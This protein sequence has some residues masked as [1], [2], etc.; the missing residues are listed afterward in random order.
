[1][2]PTGSGDSHTHIRAAIG[3]LEFDFWFDKGFAP[4][5]Q[6]HAIESHNHSL[7]ELHFIL[8]GS[9]TLYV[10]Q[11]EQPLMP[12]TW[13][14]I[15]PGTYHA[16]RQH[17]HDP[18]VR[19]YIQFSCHPSKPRKMRRDRDNEEESATIAAILSRLTYVTHKDAS[20]HIQWIADIHHEFRR[21]RIGYMTR[22]R[23]LLTLVVLD[24]IRETEPGARI[25]Y[26]PPSE[27]KD[28][29]RGAE[30][31]RFF[32]QYSEPLTIGDLARTLNLSTK[33]TNRVILEQYGTTFKQKL[34]DTRIE[35]AK[36]LLATTDLAVQDI[37]ERVGYAL[38][39]SFVHV[40]KRKTGQTPIEY[41]RNKKKRPA[42][43]P[44]NDSASRQNNSI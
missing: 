37:S 4:I 31:D 23:C 28:D 25:G 22:I 40:F 2:S 16:I 17:R 32:D 21:Q 42:S 7:F 18:L 5:G 36:R 14:L 10:D 26:L 39:R 30:I 43:S 27:S 6:H 15:G 35:E 3:G 24:V 12:N 41:R 8:S 44:G 38:H 13:H 19:S 20:R 9:G 29:L 33:Q 1:M 34:L 11:R